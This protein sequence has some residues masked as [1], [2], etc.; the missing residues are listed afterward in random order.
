[1][2]KDT[3]R[4]LSQGFMV[5]SILTILFVCG[6]CCLNSQKGTYGP[7][8]YYVKPGGGVG[9]GAKYYNSSTDSSMLGVLI[10]GPLFVLFS[11][12]SAV[13]DGIS[14]KEDKGE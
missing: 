10:G 1:M 6:N 3:A 5:V 4:L 13:F 12:T 9:Y 8:E 2:K 14:K 11:I 7:E